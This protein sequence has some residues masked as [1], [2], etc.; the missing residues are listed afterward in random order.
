MGELRIN[1]AREF[2]FGGYSW[3]VEWG[4]DW[5]ISDWLVVALFRAWRR[6]RARRVRGRSHD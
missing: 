6:D 4:S 2:C 1:I 3:Y 5:A